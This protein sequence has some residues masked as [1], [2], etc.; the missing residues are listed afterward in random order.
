ML[1]KRNYFLHQLKNYNIS[2]LFR[3]DVR[4][5]RIISKKKSLRGKFEK[6]RAS[7]CLEMT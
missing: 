1:K 2:L 5:I 3:M 4:V 7:Y 6:L